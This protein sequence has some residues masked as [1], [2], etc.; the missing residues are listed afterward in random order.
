MV[1]LARFLYVVGFA[2]FFGMA[3]CGDSKRAAAPDFVFPDAGMDAGNGESD[4]G[5]NE[6]GE[7]GDAGSDAPL[8]GAPVDGECCT[9]ETRDTFS[10]MSGREVESITKS[11]SIF[12]HYTPLSGPPSDDPGNP[13]ALSSL[14]RYA[15]EGPPPG[16]CFGV[17]ETCVFD[18]RTVYYDGS[19][20]IESITARGK[21]WNWV[22]VD[23]DTYVPADNNGSNL[24]DVIRYSED[25]SS[26]CYDFVDDCV[27][28]TRDVYADPTHNQRI[29]SITAYGKMYRFL[30]NLSND[31]VTPDAAN[32]TLLT[33]ISHYAAGPCVGKSGAD[34]VFDTLDISTDNLSSRWI[35]MVTAYGKYFIFYI[36]YS[37]NTTT[38]GGS[39][40]LSSVSRY[41]TAECAGTT[42]AACP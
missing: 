33:A 8:D 23:E 40:Y 10:E 16:P 13:F 35:E 41:E 7:V 38:S 30:T 28:E 34:C 1:T 27:F 29:E 42:M 31:E 36:Q 18:S 24:G 20:F 6:D 3:G 19:S 12:F 21:F 22:I 4:S 2:V 11:G 9:F 37:N 15:E 14:L 39:G 17:T 25:A 5:S 26:P 32:G